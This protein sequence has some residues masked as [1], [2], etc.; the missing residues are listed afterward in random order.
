[1][2]KSNTS[3]REL[4]LDRFV[5]RPTLGATGMIHIRVVRINGA[6]LLASKD[7]IRASRRAELPAA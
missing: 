7:A 2:K 5:E 1:M 3:K 6:T 4:K